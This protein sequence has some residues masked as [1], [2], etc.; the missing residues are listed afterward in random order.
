M[1]PAEPD[2]FGVC[3][4]EA[5]DESTMVCDDESDDDE[6]QSIN[7]FNGIAAYMLD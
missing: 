6:D 2:V 4:V 7:D 5:E 3:Q 1:I